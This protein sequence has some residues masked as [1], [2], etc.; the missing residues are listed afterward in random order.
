M[1]VNVVELRAHPAQAEDIHGKKAVDKDGKPVPLFPDERSIYA[2]GILV[3]YV[4][5]APER[6]P[7]FIH[8][9]CGADAE[10]VAE[11]KELIKKEF[12][13]TPTRST[14]VTAP[15]DAEPVATEYEDFGIED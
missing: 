2:D 8:H 6:I 5:S 11:V 1:H 10:F 9:A 15:K 7:M 4:G 14:N 13:V 12:G 3:G